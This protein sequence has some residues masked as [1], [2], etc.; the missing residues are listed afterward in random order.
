[1]DFPTNVINKLNA[2]FAQQDGT[3]PEPDE[4]QDNIVSPD[5]NDIPEI[6]NQ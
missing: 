1:M 4:E 5:Q 2:Y 6:S 3:N